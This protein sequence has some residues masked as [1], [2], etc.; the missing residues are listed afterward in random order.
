MKTVLKQRKGVWLVLCAVSVFSLTQSVQAASFDCAK[1]QTQVERLI[2]ED[3]ELSMLDE[4]LA[5]EYAAASK[6]DGKTGMIRQQQQKWLKVRN[7]CTNALCVKNEY[8][9]Q[10]SKLAEFA[11]ANAGWDFVLHKGG[12]VE[13]WLENGNDPMC[14]Q[15]KDYM[16]EVAR[17]WDVRESGPPKN[18]CSGTLGLA[19]FFSEPPWTELDPKKHEDLIMRLMWFGQAKYEYFKVHPPRPGWDEEYFRER[20]R[21]FIDRGGRLQHWRARIAERFYFPPDGNDKPAPPGEQ[22]VVQLRSVWDQSSR[23]VTR[24]TDCRL[25]NWSGQVFL[26]ASD[27][28]GPIRHLDRNESLVLYHGDPILISSSDGEVSARSPIRNRAK[29]RCRLTYPNHTSE[30]GVPGSG[31]AFCL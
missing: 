15:I 16:N 7:S 17:K 28:S 9:A 8:F 5:E 14:Q 19:P 31:L 22:D 10:I 20:A 4:R 1:A 12:A 21:D 2:C 18:H 11:Q 25:P 26:V 3:A 30:D 13:D 6:I 24:A 27:L 23:V 29:H